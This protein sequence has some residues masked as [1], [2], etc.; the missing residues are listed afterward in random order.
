VLAQLTAVCKPEERVVW[1]RQMADCLQYAVALSPRNDRTSLTRLTLLE[2]QAAAS[3]PGS[4]LAAYIAYRAIQAECSTA[5]AAEEAPEAITRRQEQWRGRL[6][7]FVNA[8]PNSEEAKPA[9]MDLAL[10]CEYMNRD[11]EAR[12]WYQ[13]VAS[14]YPGQ[15]IARKAEGAMR[16]LNL[17]GQEL[18]LA[19]PLVFTRHPRHDIPF[20]ID[21]LRGKPVVVYFWSSKDLVC[22]HDFEELRALRE[23]HAKNGL[24]LLCVNMDD[25]PQQART[26][27]GEVKAPGVHVFQRGGLDG[28]VATRFGLL[29]VPTVMLVG[30]DGRVVQHDAEIGAL[31]KAISRKF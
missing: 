30:P 18:R 15:P 24:E 8:Y 22:L 10:V 20:D 5:L 14:Q 9:L 23:R 21:Q 6:E 7:Q 17:D 26:I 19:L 3:M 16:R 27:L 29:V 4:N 2:Q 1:I 25:E 12:L 13:H 31:D 28:I 11:Q